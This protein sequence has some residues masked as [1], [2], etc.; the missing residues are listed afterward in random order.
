M[1]D[2]ITFSILAKK[3]PQMEEH[4]PDSAIEALYGAK[5]GAVPA[6]KL[7][8]RHHK[9]GHSSHHRK[10]KPFDSG[11]AYRPYLLV[12]TVAVVVTVLIFLVS[13]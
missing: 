6:K 9:H 2:P 10:S 13:K 5:P 7:P 12:G 3:I 4:V 8:G 11:P 1:E